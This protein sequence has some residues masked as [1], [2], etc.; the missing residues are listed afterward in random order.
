MGIHMIFAAVLAVASANTRAAIELPNEVVGDEAAVVISWQ[1]DHPMA[2]GMVS[3]LSL[4]LLFPEFANDARTEKAVRAI[5]QGHGVA[6]FP[7]IKD[8]ATEIYDRSKRVGTGVSAGILLAASM[9]GLWR[10]V[11]SRKTAHG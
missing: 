7:Y 3:G 2:A 6:S 1:V 9:F 5:G 4:G 8:S 11:Q 10:L